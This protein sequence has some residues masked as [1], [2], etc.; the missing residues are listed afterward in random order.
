M[1]DI[2]IELLTMLFLMREWDCIA[3]SKLLSIVSNS[4]LFIFINIINN[5]INKIFARIKVKQFFAK[6]CNNEFLEKK[7]KKKNSEGNLWL[8][9]V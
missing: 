1:A 3:A 2:S 5:V 6:I 9:S 7:K 8:F 4:R